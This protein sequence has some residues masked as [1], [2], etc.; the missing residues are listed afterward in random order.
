MPH[1][2]DQDFGSL[3]AEGDWNY[4]FSDHPLSAELAKAEGVFLYDTNGNRYYDASGGPMAINLGHGHPKMKAAIT[5]QMEDYAFCHPMLAN[6]R[7]ADLCAAVAS[8]TPEPIGHPF[9]RY[10]G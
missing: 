1:D 4:V 10:S 8:V 3:T 5:A 2:L 7:R 9:A 6:R